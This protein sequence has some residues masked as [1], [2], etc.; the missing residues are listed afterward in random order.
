MYNQTELIKYENLISDEC[1]DLKK[2]KSWNETKNAVCNETIIQN[3]F[4]NFK[5]FNQAEVH[6]IDISLIN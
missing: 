5:V 1:M 3:V 4:I 6:I 2:K